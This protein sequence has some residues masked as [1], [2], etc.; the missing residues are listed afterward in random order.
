MTESVKE[1]VGNL[2]DDT[3]YYGEY[4]QQFLSNSDILNLL[5]FPEKFKVPQAKTKAMVEGNYFHTAIL[6]PE[7]LIDFKVID[8]ASRSTKAYKETC[9]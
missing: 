8:V 2:A 3:K 4:G 5:K 7:K 6:E 1:I 9:G